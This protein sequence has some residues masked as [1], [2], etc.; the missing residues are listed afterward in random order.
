[1]ILGASKVVSVSTSW[2][3]ILNLHWNQSLSI[4]YL[5]TS[6]YTEQNVA[7]DLPWFYFATPGGRELMS[8][9]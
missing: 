4:V 2:E 7:R 9:T 8:L 3:V 5:D 6:Y 1:M